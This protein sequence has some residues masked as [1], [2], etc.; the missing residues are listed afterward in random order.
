MPKF[1]NFVLM[2]DKKFEIPECE[3]LL[4]VKNSMKAKIIWTERL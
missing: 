4:K 1:D 2:A 3:T